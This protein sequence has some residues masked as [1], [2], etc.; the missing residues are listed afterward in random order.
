MFFIFYLLTLSSCPDFEE[1][2]PIGNVKIYLDGKEQS[3]FVSIQKGQT[4]TLKAEPEYSAGDITIIWEINGN[5]A[6]ITSSGVGETCTVRGE[7]V[8]T[9][10]SLSITAKAWR[11]AAERQRSKSI[12]L[13]VSSAPAATGFDSI[14]GP[15][16]ISIGEE[17]MLSA[18]LIPAW[19]DSIVT[20]TYHPLG[21][22]E[23]LVN[24]TPIPNSNSVMVKGIAPG[25]A[26]ITAATEGFSKSFSMQVTE[27]ISGNPVTG[28]RIMYNNTEAEGRQLPVQNIIWLYPGEAINL[29]AQTTGG[30]PDAISWTIN[31]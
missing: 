22:S 28:I 27:D 9:T 26:T 17:Q 31:N 16:Q 20:W 18:A 14:K 12:S 23:N 1:L 30:N 5:D 13:F 11:P 6:I 10:G 4:I 24:L 15:N 2:H 19:A 21:G 3:S 25:E 29:E 7:N 8:N